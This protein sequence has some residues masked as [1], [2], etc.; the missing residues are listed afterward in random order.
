MIHGRLISSSAGSGVTGTGDAS[1]PSSSTDNAIARFSGTDGKTIQNSPYVTI[2]DNGT[3]A[4]AIGTSG[5]GGYDGMVVT[6]SAGNAVVGVVTT[7]TAIVGQANANTG[8]AG[9]FTSA[10]TA[11]LV[12]ETSGGLLTVLRVKH[13]DAG[14]NLIGLEQ[15]ASTVGLWSSNGDISTVGGV[16][17]GSI[18]PLAPAG[19]FA[20]ASTGGYMFEGTDDTFE[21]T[22]LAT[23]PTADRTITL[24][25][26]TGTVAL[27]GTQMIHGYRALGD[28]G[29][30]LLP[31][32]DCVLTFAPS[33]DTRTLT[34][35]SATEG[36]HFFVKNLVGSADNV[37]FDGGNIDGA[38][39][40]AY[41]PIGAGVGIHLVCIG[42]TNFITV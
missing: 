42:T 6:A 20:V 39:A 4:S 32:T 8:M 31:A 2:N 33:G 5:F 15:G 13:T 24:P 10:G 37:D 26:A 36:Q 21:T 19:Y 16:T 1:G 11:V 35:A 22:L 14:R 27:V 17:A 3:I 38:A 40:S 30:T 25:D 23:D 7:G 28:S 29:T 41:G 18:S 34:L 9:Q 12:E